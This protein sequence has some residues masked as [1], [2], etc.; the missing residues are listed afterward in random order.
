MNKKG[1]YPCKDDSLLFSSSSFLWSAQSCLLV[2]PLSF[3]CLCS[4]AAA[5]RSSSNM[6]THSEFPPISWSIWITETKHCLVLHALLSLETH[7]LFRWVSV[8]IPWFYIWTLIHFCFLCSLVISRRVCSGIA[9]FAVTSK[10]VGYKECSLL[11]SE[12]R[13]LNK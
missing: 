2:A 3:T 5:H 12:V 7:S 13:G 8:D 11:W 6:S 4:H 9:C 10:G 1:T